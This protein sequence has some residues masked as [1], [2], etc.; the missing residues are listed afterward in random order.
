MG[1]VKGT[2]V[3]QLEVRQSGGGLD[4]IWTP[5]SWDNAPLIA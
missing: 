3:K 1:G 4:G 5:S 2:K